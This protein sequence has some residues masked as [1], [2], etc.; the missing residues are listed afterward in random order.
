LQRLSAHNR[1]LSMRLTWRLLRFAPRA[2]S[3]L[4]AGILA[5][6]CGGWLTIAQAWLVSRFIAEVFL[7]KRSLAALP[8]VMPAIGSLILLRALAFWIGGRSAT[9][10]SAR[11]RENVRARLFEKILALGPAFTRR[12]QTGELTA[13]LM[14]GVEN[15][16]AFFAHYLPQLVVAV[17]VPLSILLLV[18]PIDWLSGLIFLTTAP[19]LPLF[20][21]LIGKAAERTTQRQ[22]ETL[23]RLSAHFLDSLQGLITLKLF[24]RARAHAQEVDRVSERFREATLGVLRLTFLSALVLELFTAISTALVAV[25]VSLRLLYGKM[26][27][28]P[29]LL[30]LLLAPEFYLPLRMLALRFHAGMTGRT[31]ARQIWGLLEDRSPQIDLALMGTVADLPAID[32]I[33]FDAVSFTYPDE[34]SPSLQD[35]NLVLRAGQR[36]AVVG[37]SGAGKSTLVNLLLGFLQPDSGK[38]VTVYADGSV[39]EGPP[40]WN[41]VAWVSQHPY[42]FHDTIAANIRL[43]RPAA[44]EEEVIAAA[45]AAHLDEF[46]CSLPQGYQTVIGEGGA[47]LS[48]GQAQRLA[49]ARA[50]LKNAPILVLDEATASLDPRE[51]ALIMEASHSLLQGRIALVVAHRLTTVFE[52]DCIVVLDNGRIVE[53]GSHAALLAA[54]GLY[55]RLVGEG[56]R[57]ALDRRMLSAPMTTPPE[58]RPP[59]DDHVS[60]VTGMPQPWWALLGH[61]LGFLQ[62]RE[63]PV[64]LSVLL[65]VLTVGSNVG[66]MALAAWLIA[67]AALQPPLAAL[68]VAIVGVRFFGLARAV[69]RYAERLTSHEVTFRLLARLRGWFYR[70]LERLSP[71][72]LIYYRAGDLLNRAVADVETLE[73]FYGRGIAPPLVALITTAGLCLF[74]GSFVPGLAVVYLGLFLVT[75]LGIPCL[76]VAAGRRPGERLLAQRSALR[77]ALVDG[78]QGLAE[79]LL[80]GSWISYSQYISNISQKQLK[81]QKKTSHISTLLDAIFFITTQS[82]GVIIL[83]IAAIAFQS[84]QITGPWLAALFL[85]ALA[86]F[87]AVAPLP[88][89]AQML[90]TSLRAGERLFDIVDAGAEQKEQEQD[91]R[92]QKGLLMD[93]GPKKPS[94]SPPALEFRRLTFAYAATEGPVL[95]N[96]SFSLPPGAR[97]AI[98]GP[99]GAGKSTLVH[100]LLRFWQPPSG[101]IWLQGNDL[102]S[103]D[104]EKTRSLFGVAPQSP[105]FFYATLGENLLLAN[106]EAS[107]REV[108]WA[109]EQALLS[110]FV[111]QLP[112]GLNTLIG[113]RGLRLS[114]GER[115]RLSL[116]RALLTRAPILIL[117][118]PT[119]H[120]DTLTERA[121]LANLYRLPRS[122]SLLLITH[123]LIGLENMDEILVLDQGRIVERGTHPDLLQQRGLYARMFAWQQRILPE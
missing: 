23:S 68:Q 115:Q 121:I 83:L 5:Q 109:L 105:F 39:R 69:F 119:A 90:V 73:N 75:A 44:T 80:A 116:A 41:A 93:D 3:L 43:A 70:A 78:V 21:M 33:V 91:L 101:S 85:A 81:T 108:E 52:A 114:G 2:R 99:S 96:V 46:I 4:A 86:G 31:A 107:A 36:L 24:G 79:I 54:R 104:V 123:R 6:I 22:W 74:F 1:F 30:V 37:R 106:P 19:L 25:A 110:D 113:E 26:A 111:A 48:A 56:E 112:Q 29:A 117:D 58:A 13:I 49:L 61:L 95:R 89:A 63:G 12:R 103:Y 88:T 100:L 35:V 27:F 16:D 8:G 62:G 97:L 59:A 118:E 45:R 98:V 47:R 65:G 11:V 92:S 94:S 51:E 84:G 18:F 38:I 76:A 40:P 15:L 34:H 64:V 10:L 77:V 102:L 28:P 17:V 50:F 9:A 14:E 7:A 60:A 122:Q 20:M 72:R 66:L 57:L 82:G 87:E 71:A 120:L 53:R 67:T 55:A 32:S 42:L